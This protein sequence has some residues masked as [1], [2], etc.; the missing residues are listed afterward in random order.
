MADDRVIPATADWNA[1]QRA[2]LATYAEGEFQHLIKSRPGTITHDD[3]G[4]TLLRFL[5]I[6]LSNDEDC[7]DHETA[8]HRLSR[9]INDV[10]MS[11]QAVRDLTN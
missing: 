6:E 7:C 9:A 1:Y 4:D 10:Q 2:V 5:L 8:C 3:L 11:L